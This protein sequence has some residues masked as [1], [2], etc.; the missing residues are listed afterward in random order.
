MPPKQARPTRP[1]P[2]ASIAEKG[3]SAVRAFAI[4][5]IAGSASAI[6][7]LNLS[8]VYG[9]IPA[10]MY[11]SRA[12][13]IVALAALI[14]KD[15]IKKLIPFKKPS[16]FLSVI[17]YWTPVIQFYLFKLSGPFGSTLGPIVTEGLT[18]Y[19]LLLVAIYSASELLE[20]VELKSWNPTL[21][22]M[23]KPIA[24]YGLVSVVSKAAEILM[25]P[26]I[27]THNFMTRSGLQ[28]LVGSAYAALSTNWNAVLL[29]APAMLHTVRINPHYHSPG[30]TEL[31]N[32]TLHSYNYTLLERQESLTGY[33][34]VLES[35]DNQFRVLRCDHSLLGGNWLLTPERVEFGQQ[36]PETI[37]SVF[38][39]LEA[40]RLVEVPHQ[41]PDSEKSALV[42]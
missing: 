25:P 29:C 2:P 42:M 5:V 30:A 33:I 10:S 4:L 12:M 9:S 35:W 26:Y 21:R 16:D 6:S 1:K 41:K 23:V 7:Q 3:L 32:K 36:F 40:V 8:P 39:M 19:P 34:S 38:T 13:T 31:L 17:A 27:G 18:Y 37:Y 22:D 28:L 20:V 15:H 24:S 14:G 11:H